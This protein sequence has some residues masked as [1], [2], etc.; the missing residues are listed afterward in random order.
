MLDDD[1]ADRRVGKHP[2]EF[3]T[4]VVHTGTGL[5]DRLWVV[6]THIQGERLQPVG[7]PLQVGFL[8]G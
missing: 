7:L 1:R 6:D 4:P 2:V 3:A 5:R 8:V